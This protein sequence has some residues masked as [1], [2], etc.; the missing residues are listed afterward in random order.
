MATPERAWRSP[1]LI[2]AKVDVSLLAKL[3]PD[4][5]ALDELLASGLLVAD[6]RWLRFRHE[7]A[8]LAMAQAIPCAALP[9]HRA[10]TTAVFAAA[11]GADMHLVLSP[12]FTIGLKTP[13]RGLTCAVGL[14]AA[15]ATAVPCAAKA[16]ISAPAHNNIP[17]IFLR[18]FKA[19]PFSLGLWKLTGP[20]DDAMRPARGRYRE[21]FPMFGGPVPHVRRGVPR[22]G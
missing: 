1:S 7:I 11:V 20:N 22:R 16:V 18:I 15:C 2:G 21:Q 5:T 8:R 6:G 14:G 19:L 17:T 13:A 10:S 9:S 3:C 12:K 4:P